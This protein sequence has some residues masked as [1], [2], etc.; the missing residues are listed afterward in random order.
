MF[1]AFTTGALL[2]LSYASIAPGQTDRDEP[3]P[4]ALC[5]LARD[6]SRFNGRMISIRQH[7]SISFED[8]ELF[9]AGSDQPNVG[10]IW[11]EYGTGLARQPTTWC[12]GDLKPRDKLRNSENSISI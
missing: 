2:A 6:V 12:C 9:A 7:V 1:L 11:L 8:F 3:Q 5:D 4:V 10:G